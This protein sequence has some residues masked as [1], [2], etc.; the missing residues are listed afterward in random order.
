MQV[1]YHL[2]KAHQGSHEYIQDLHIHTLLIFTEIQRSK[3]KIRKNKLS[4]Y[5]THHYLLHL[6]AIIL[7]YLIAVFLPISIP[8]GIYF[9]LFIWFYSKY[10]VICEFFILCFKYS[11]NMWIKFT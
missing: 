3:I 1:I 8:K 7:S 4:T 9:H 6:S 5:Y 10:I 11:S 2:Y